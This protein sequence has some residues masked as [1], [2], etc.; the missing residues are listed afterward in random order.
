MKLDRT[1]LAI[2]GIAVILLVAGPVVPAWMTSL[3]KLSLGYGV[4]VLGMMILMRTGLV[5]FGH[6]LY[7]CLGAYA[8]AAHDKVAN[9]LAEAG[10][11]S[12][13]PLRA[14]AGAPKA[15][16]D[17]LSGVFGPYDMAVMI[18]MAALVTGFTAWVLG[19]LLRKYRE[20]FFAMLSLAF[21]MILYGL[22]VKSSALGSTDGFN[23][24]AR[25]IMGVAL[26]GD[27]ALLG[28]HQEH[29]A[30]V[31]IE[32]ACVGEIQPDRPDRPP[33][34]Q[35]RQGDQRVLGVLPLAA[36]RRQEMPV[37][38]GQSRE[39][40]RRA[41]PKC[42][43]QRRDDIA[44]EALMLADRVR[45]IA[46]LAEPG[47]PVAGRRDRDNQSRRRRQLACRVV[48]EHR[49]HIRHGDRLAEGR[50]DGLQADRAERD[51][52]VGFVHCA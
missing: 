31:G 6:G 49:D 34:R 33:A 28:E 44:G 36:T 15:V 22:L 30:I 43:G 7:Y 29:R 11:Q 21:S 23:I 1:S 51:A 8:A 48:E 35:E 52:R 19:F 18:A 17:G 10:A 39:D 12:W 3:I 50:R 25:S 9:A 4:V 5:S 14:L 32:V 38:P 27:G 40:N 16:V 46:K 26:E 45:R 37:V 41:G 24:A 42:L 13:A 47:E 2:A 20:I